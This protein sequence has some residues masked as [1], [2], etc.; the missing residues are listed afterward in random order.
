M[1]DNEFIN[2]CSKNLSIKEKTETFSS[3]VSHQ[4]DTTNSNENMIYNLIDI[5]NFR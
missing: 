3:Y 4:Y 1:E 5:E 2:I